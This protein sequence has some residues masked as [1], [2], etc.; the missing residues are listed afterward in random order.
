MTMN[1]PLP[2]EDEMLAP[3]LLEAFATAHAA[4][5][6][7]AALAARVKRRLMARIAEDSTPR[8]HTVQH[9]DNAW[10]PFTRGVD[11]KVLN[12]AEGIMSYLLR[13]AP[14]ASF[15]SHRHPID[16]ECVVLEGTIQIGTELVVAAGGFHLAHRDTVHAPVSTVAGATIY[17]RGASPHPADLV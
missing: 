13:L 8:H 7:S 6:P 4:D 17:L 3:D 16:E 10:Q 2:P 1:T 11:I 5:T 14:G 9:A 12:E 15:P